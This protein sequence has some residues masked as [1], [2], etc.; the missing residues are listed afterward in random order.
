VIK[1]ALARGLS[2]RC[3]GG[4]SGPMFAMD[5][6]HKGKKSAHGSA[7]ALDAKLV[8]LY[9]MMARYADE[10]AQS[11]SAASASPFSSQSGA[12]ARRERGRFEEDDEELAEL[13][14]QIAKLEHQIL[15]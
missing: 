9:R 11:Q 12:V 13:K 10:Q 6:A 7:L 8:P 1:P 3:I 4:E 15:R 5:P 2:S 14:R